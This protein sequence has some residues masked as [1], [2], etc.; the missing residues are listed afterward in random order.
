[1]TGEDPKPQR[2]RLN[3]LE[4]GRR[5]D[6]DIKREKTENFWMWA[7]APWE[8]GSCDAGGASVHWEAF[9]QVGPR[10]C[11]RIL[12]NQAKPGLR[13]P[14]ELH[15]SAHKQL[16]DCGP[17]QMVGSGDQ[18][19]PSEAPWY[20]GRAGV[21]GEAYK[22]LQ[23]TQNVSLSADL[24]SRKKSTETPWHRGWACWGK[25]SA[26]KARNAEGGKGELK[27]VRRSPVA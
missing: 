22:P 6:G 15:F 8:G 5:E 20:R 19:K 26:D 11:C 25:T 16:T 2:G 12:E 14:R 17:N 1:M 18:E 13:W 3:F 27:H 21:L 23:R 7:C 4:W 24:G 10:G 9:S